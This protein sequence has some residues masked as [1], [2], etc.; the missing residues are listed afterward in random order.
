ME[1]E[2]PALRLVPFTFDIAG[3]RWRIE[4]VRDQQ[5][6]LELSDRLD[7]FPFGLLLW[8]SAPA[9]ATALAER[10]PD[11]TGRRVLEIGAGT[12]LPGMVAAYLGAEVVAIDHSASAV[13]LARRNAA[14]NG[15]AGIHNV[16]A[17]W[18]RFGSPE[19]FDLILGADVLYDRDAHGIVLDVVT[20]CLAPDGR[21]LFADPSRQ[22]TPLF[23]RRLEE[24]FEVVRTAREEPVL[25]PSSGL[26]TVVVTILDGTLRS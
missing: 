10:C 22:D 3:R 24:S 19:P 18:T 2:L 16:E 26:Q 21:V 8:E 20:R 12:G 25:V 11:L 17:D 4:A 9:L 23:I 6:L 13:A 5:A 14:E 1:P 15:V 7:A